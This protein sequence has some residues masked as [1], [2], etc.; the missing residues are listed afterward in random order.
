LSH[1]EG[2]RPDAAELARSLRQYLYDKYVY[3]G[4]SDAGSA[5]SARL[6]AVAGGRYD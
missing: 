1:G 3:R 2:G 4:G 5:E 6:T